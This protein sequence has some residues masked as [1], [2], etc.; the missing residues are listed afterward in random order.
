MNRTLRSIA[1]AAATILAPACSSSHSETVTRL[2]GDVLE[3]QPCNLDRGVYCVEGLECG[4]ITASNPFCVDPAKTYVAC[5]NVVLNDG[6]LAFC[7][8]GAADPNAENLDT[9][10]YSKPCNDKANPDADTALC[11]SADTDSFCS[12]T[13]ASWQCVRNNANTCQC[14]YGGAKPTDSSDA[15]PKCN[16]QVTRGSNEHCCQRRLPGQA[17][18]ICMCQDGACDSDDTELAS[19]DVPF[20]RSCATFDKASGAFRTPVTD[21]RR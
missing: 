1:V 13:F 5:S 14:A 7:G 9:D 3:G 16:T 6:F 8:C 17:E 19:C 21:C 12:C 20:P 11:C 10:A 4:T 15:I 18:G 2:V